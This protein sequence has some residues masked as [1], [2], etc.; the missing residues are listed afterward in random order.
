MGEFEERGRELGKLVDEKRA[1]YGDSFGASAAFLRLLYHDGVK[2][3]QY[4]DLL[5]IARI[6][7][8]LKRI[9]T[10]GASDPMGEHPAR[11]IAG[12]AMLLDAAA[13]EMGGPSPATDPLDVLMVDV[14]S[15]ILDRERGGFVDHLPYDVATVIRAQQLGYVVMKVPCSKDLGQDEVRYV[16]APLGHAFLARH[17]KGGA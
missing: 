17:R 12:Y 9:A 2:P 1:A 8:K 10:N 13:K 16:V 11:D 6:F 14:L 15:K 4:T 3:E 5:A 7:D